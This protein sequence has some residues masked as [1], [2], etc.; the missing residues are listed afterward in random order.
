MN[1][2][3]PA[4]IPYFE[5]EPGDNVVAYCETCRKPVFVGNDKTRIGNFVLRGQVI[6]HKN[7]FVE[8]HQIDLVYPRKGKNHIVDSKILDQKVWFTTQP[9]RSS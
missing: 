6:G 4:E 9:F 7:F 2:R 3:E 1:E 5:L 8:N